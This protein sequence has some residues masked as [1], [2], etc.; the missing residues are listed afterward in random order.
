M[1]MEENNPDGSRVVEMLAKLLQ[2]Q[3]IDKEEILRHLKSLETRMHDDDNKQE[4]IVQQQ[5]KDKEDILHQ[6]QTYEKQNAQRFDRVEKHLDSTKKQ[7]Q[8]QGQQSTVME[9][10]LQQSLTSQNAQI[11]QIQSG[12]AKTTQKVQLLDKQQEQVRKETKNTRENMSTLEAGVKEMRHEPGKMRDNERARMEL[13]RQQMF[14]LNR[15]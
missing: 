5:T 9:A 2:Q 3:A 6:M 7:L 13:H 14:S 10:T 8:K 4:K 1:P 12:C 15:M 11:L